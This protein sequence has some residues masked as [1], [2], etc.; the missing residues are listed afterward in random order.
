MADVL[1]CSSVGVGEGWKEMVGE[2]WKEV[3]REGWGGRGGEGEVGRERWGGRGG[4]ENTTVAIKTC[5]GQRI[6]F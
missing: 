1:S 5:Q 6:N 3:G 4:R 2:G